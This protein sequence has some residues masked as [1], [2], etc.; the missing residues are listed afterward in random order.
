MC[1]VERLMNVNI[2][3][4]DKDI[5][6]YKIV[7]KADKKSC[8]SCVQ[9]FMYEANILYK[10]PSIEL[11]KSY[12]Y[13]TYSVLSIIFVQKA[14]HSYTKIQQTLSRIYSKGSIYE[15]RGIIAGNQLMSI[16]LD[17]PYYVA[18]FVIP[19][20]SQYAV[21]WRGEIISNQIIYTGNYIKV[22]PDTKY[23]TRELWK[24]K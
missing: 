5:E 14:Y 13:R 1:W 21:N 8:E 16:R 9:G 12:M 3:I 10:I 24:E 11:K 15:N 17:N 22:Q 7:C 19:K 18:T 20:G 4:T 23:D 6:V 2:Q